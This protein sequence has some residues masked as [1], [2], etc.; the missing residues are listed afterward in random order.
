MKKTKKNSAT[1][2]VNEVSTRI[3]AKNRSIALA[4]IGQYRQKKTGFG[5]N[6]CSF[7][8]FFV[9]RLLKKRYKKWL[10]YRNTQAS[11]GN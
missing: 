7:L 9:L 11:T 1:I 5:T 10:L 6:F 3:F 2:A 4:A 8:P